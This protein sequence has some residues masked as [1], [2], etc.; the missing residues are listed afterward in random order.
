[1][2]LTPR[3]RNREDI[4]LKGIAMRTH[5]LGLLACAAALLATNAA[6]ADFNLSFTAGERGASVNFHAD[7]SGN[8][9]VTL[10]NTGSYALTPGLPGGFDPPHILT[11]LFWDVTGTVTLSPSSEALNAGSTMANGGNAATVASQWDY[12]QSASGLG[13]SPAL[14][15]HYGIGA[16]GFGGVFGAGDHN[17]AGGTG[18]IDGIDYGLTTAD[19]PDGGGNGGVNGVALERDSVVFTLSGWTLGD[20]MSIISNIRF[21]YGSALD[22]FFGPPPPPPVPVPAGVVLL[23]MG[24]ALTGFYGWRKRRQPKVA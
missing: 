2:L 17:F 13:G 1:L 9:I 8:L 7:G 11:G 24:G 23:G 10:T 21:Q 15:Q 4:L 19:Y 5:I 18:S 22:E 12:R 3:E 6:R 14:S 16:A 20:P